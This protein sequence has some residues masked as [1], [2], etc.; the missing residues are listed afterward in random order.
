M[1]SVQIRISRDLGKVIGA[2][3]TNATVGRVASPALDYTWHITH[4]LFT[5]ILAGFTVNNRVLRLPAIVLL[6]TK[7]RTDN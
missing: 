1:S 5:D 2:E 6:N 7:N 4:I 3:S